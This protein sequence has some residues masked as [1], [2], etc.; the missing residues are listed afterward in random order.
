MIQKHKPS[1]LPS[2]SSLLWARGSQ[3]FTS[4]SAVVEHP[5]LAMLEGCEGPAGGISIPLD[6]TLP[7]A[8]AF[9]KAAKQKRFLLAPRAAKLRQTPSPLSCCQAL[10]GWDLL[11]EQ[12]A[13]CWLPREVSPLTHCWQGINNKRQD[14]TMQRGNRRVP[15]GGSSASPWP[16]GPRV[17]PL[18]ALLPLPVWWEMP[19]PSEA[20]PQ[21]HWH[22]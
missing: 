17:Q 16:P 18:G 12:P 10:P 21:P 6:Y 4:S 11:S 7:D 5:L 3:N 9:G 8:D 14:S 19:D 20:S 2:P 15:C 22:V 1:A 13:Q